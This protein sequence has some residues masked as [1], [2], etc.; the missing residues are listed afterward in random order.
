MTRSASP[1]S[2]WPGR[3]RTRSTDGLGVER[4]EIVEIGDMRQDR[5]GDLD[6][7]LRLGG[8]RCSSASASSAGSS[9]ASGKNGT[10]P[11]GSQPVARAIAA[12]PSA[13]S[14][15]SPRNL[16]TRKPW[17]SAASSASIT[18]LVPTRLAI[19]PPRSMSPISTT[20]TS[21]ARAKPILAMSLARRLI[22][23]ALPAPSTST[24]SASRLQPREAVQHERHQ[25][26]LHAADTPR[27]CAARG[28]GPAPRSARRPRSAA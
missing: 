19:T 15:G 8:A 17:I 27:P 24:M 3:T 1:G 11:S 12:M 7:R 9:R 14:G 20:G 25:L 18:A 16:L 22:S 2:A 5:D 26:R 13:N 28:R 4:I 10:R 21:A 23:E 6:P